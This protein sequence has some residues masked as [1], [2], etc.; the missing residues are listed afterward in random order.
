MNFSLINRV[1]L[2]SLDILARCVLNL[3]FLVVLI[4]AVLSASVRYYLPKIDQYRETILA[5][6]ND[7]P[8]GVVVTADRINSEWRPFR[9]AI[10]L[11][12]V[13]I[14]HPDWDKALDLQELVLEL[15]IIQTLV[16]QQMRLSRIELSE[17]A[18][19]FAQDPN[20]KWALAGLFSEQESQTDVRKLL[21]RIWAVKNIR[22]QNINVS[23]QPKGKPRVQLPAL[24]VDVVSEGDGKRIVA[25]LQQQKAAISTLIIDT[26]GQPFADDFIAKAYWQLLDYPAKGLLGLFSD[27]HHVQSVRV[28]GDFWLNYSASHVDLRG[29]VQLND[30]LVHLPK[31]KPSTALNSGVAAEIDGD[32]SKNTDLEVAGD[33]GGDASEPRRISVEQL[34]SEFLLRQSEVGIEFWAPTVDIRYNNGK[35]LQLE[36]LALS[37]HDDSQLRLARVELDAL[38]GFIQ[39]LPLPPALNLAIKDLAPKGVMRQLHLSLMTADSTLL[40]SASLMQEKA[41]GVDAAKVAENSAAKTWDFSLSAALDEVSV[42]AWKGAPA[43]TNIDG[44]LSASKLA[45]NIKLN[46]EDLSITFPKLYDNSMIFGRASALVSWSIDSSDIYVSGRQL[47]LFGDYGQAWGEF[48]LQLPRDKMLGDVPRLILDIGLRDSHSRYRKYF[49]PKILPPALL[50]WLDESIHDGVIKQGGFIYHGPIKAPAIA[51]DTLPENKSIQLWLDIADGRL[52][53]LPHWPEVEKVNGHVLVD[54]RQVKAVID[55]AK[56][57]GLAVRDIQLQVKPT[58]NG[59]RQQSIDISAQAQGEVSSVLAF[60]QASPLND[61]LDFMQ[62]WQAPVGRASANL[63]VSTVIQDAQQQLNVEI[64]SY[65]R[66]ASLHLPS[67]ALQVDAIN[68]PLQYSWTKGLSSKGLNATFWGQPVAAKI[69]SNRIKA[70]LESHIN[71]DV[72]ADSKDISLWTRQPVLAL[73]EGHSRFKGD[74]YFGAAGAG[75]NIQSDLIGMTLDLPQP[76]DK[77][78]DEERLFKFNLP[79]SGDQRELVATVGSGLEVRFL[80]AEDG[81]KAGQVNLGVKKS[82][83]ENHKI[84]VGGQLAFAD[85]DHWLT[86]F[87]RYDQVAQDFEQRLAQSPYA[88]KAS[89]KDKQAE[90]Q[91]RTA[92]PW[93][94]EVEKLKIRQLN[95]YGQQLDNVEY[96]LFD[97]ASYWQMVIKHPQMNGKLRIFR[98]TSIPLSLNIQHVD[99]DFLSADMPVKEG[100]A[101]RLALKSD[102]PEKAVAADVTVADEMPKVTEAFEVVKQIHGLAD[103]ALAK[104]PAMDV[105]ISSVWWNKEDYGEWQFQLRSYESYLAFEDLQ[106]SVKHLQL[107]GTDTQDAELRWSFGKE[108]ETQFNGRFMGANLADV[109]ASWGYSQEIVSESARF[110][111]TAQWQGVPTDFAIGKVQ[112]DTRFE[113][114]NGSFADVSSS[115]TS[116]LKFVGFLNLS[117]LVKRLQLDFSDLSSKG[118]A[119]DRVD[120]QVLLDNGVFTLKDELHVKAPSSDIKLKGWADVNRDKVDMV[121]GVSLPLATNLPWVVAL[122]AGLPAA[123]GVYVIS[124]LLKKQVS[125]LFSA[126]YRVKGNLNEPEVNFVRLFD[127]GLPDLSELKDDKD[128]LSSEVDADAKLPEASVVQPVKQAPISSSSQP[129]PSSELLPAEPEPPTA[130]D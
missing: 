8:R 100:A 116:A 29:Q 32:T 16:H 120:G 117:L 72:L 125:T 39:T 41:E 46:S 123:A 69:T 5:E 62:H 2:K 127:T 12:G 44:I 47:D 11:E 101:D 102:I 75:L 40:E 107:S 105:V 85:V 87:H 38:A 7:N 86:A 45:G 91:E 90:V 119:Y 93:E 111:V 58:T 115:Q 121:M 65:I 36:Q 34:S 15:D 81:F 94:V 71:F 49:I 83:Y 108:A 106:A 4:S 50:K 37:H 109:L 13:S 76:F 60:L 112:G 30:V 42:N 99:L 113:W 70:G 51:M 80:L 89:T 31:T 20:G 28:K 9:P 61:K 130:A 19:L 126:V 114:N 1:A 57:G 128:E 95:A 97:T 33:V 79:F 74:I 10:G 104:F 23:L 92:M 52:A 78:V 103:P 98:D 66:G 22:L 21:D 73:L 67:H 96:D 27:D 3:F 18:L 17:L 56:L 26:D 55:K 53:Y 110:D 129:E 59:K 118:L 43:L 77:A 24:E 48:Y 84:L 68:G 6:L 124:K 88:V 54:D 25:G 63:Q 122:A 35:R 14:K 82:R 64:D